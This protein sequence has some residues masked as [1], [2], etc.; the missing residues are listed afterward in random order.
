MR[1]AI[2][3][4]FQSVIRSERGR[5]V[6]RGRGESAP[7]YE[8]SEPTMLL[9]SN[10]RSPQ[11]FVTARNGPWTRARRRLRA[12]SLD[13]QLAAGRSPESSRLLASRAQQLVSPT[14]RTDL[15]RGWKRVVELCLSAPVPRNHRAPMCR[16]RIA[17]AAPEVR[18]M[19]SVLE[20][21][22]PTAVRGFA[23][24]SLLLQ[25]GAGPLFNRHCPI[26]LRAVLRDATEQLDPFV[27]LDA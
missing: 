10:P 19:L 24:V 11:Q 7:S 5:K 3:Y 21:P 23:T 6:P 2:W 22:A 15:V 1:N 25:D 17:D 4:G 20:S 9:F 14:S 8:S 13:Q 27:V 12:R 18:A 26:D 16:R